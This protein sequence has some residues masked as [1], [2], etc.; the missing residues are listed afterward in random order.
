MAQNNVNEMGEKN[1]Q[2]LFLETKTKELQSQNNDDASTL[3]HTLTELK[4][5]QKE[6]TMLIHSHRVSLA[7]A[8]R[9]RKT[10]L[11]DSLM[12]QMTGLEENLH[13]TKVSLAHMESDLDDLKLIHAQCPAQPNVTGDPHTVQG[14]DDA[15]EDQDTE[16]QNQDQCTDDAHGDEDADDAHGDEDADDAHGDED[17]DDAHGDEDAED[18][19]GGQGT[20]GLSEGNDSE[21]PSGGQSTQGSSGG[22]G[23]DHTTQEVPQRLRCYGSKP[24]RSSDNNYAVQFSDAAHDMYGN[25]T[26]DTQDKQ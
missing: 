15:R 22:Q 18:L 11:V 4:T 25:D 21:N 9:M 13:N 19:Y 17:A 20:E 23:T 2:I 7:L 12:H 24:A 3:K 1:D 5:M 8:A 10:P 14:T 6:H 26:Q 16:D